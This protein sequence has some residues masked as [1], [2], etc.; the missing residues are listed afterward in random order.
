MTKS[1]RRTWWNFTLRTLLGMLMFVAA[2]FAGWV[3]HREWNQ[4]NV[5]E[6]IRNSAKQIGGPTTIETEDDAPGVLIVRGNRHDVLEM[7]A[8]LGD[9]DSAARK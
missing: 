9:I 6:L 5:E 3:S 4:R 8:A 1:T 7:K 2:Y